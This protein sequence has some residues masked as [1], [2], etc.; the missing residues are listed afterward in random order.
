MA[1]ARPSIGT[2]RRTARQHLLSFANANRPA[3]KQQR[4]FVALII[5][6]S[7]P[8]L[9]QH[10]NIDVASRPC[11]KMRSSNWL[12][13]EI[14]QQRALPTMAIAADK[15]SPWSSFHAA[16][17]IRYRDDGSHRLPPP[18]KRAEYAPTSGNPLLY[19]GAA[20]EN[21]RLEPT[22]RLQ[23]LRSK[24]KYI[25][26]SSQWKTPAGWEAFPKDHIIS[27]A[28][29]GAAWCPGITPLR[30]APGQYSQATRS[31]G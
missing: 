23:P 1:P 6:P 4:S 15:L 22:L 12:R 2:A 30:T 31:M 8:A 20:P 17:L 29:S 24:E 25:Q 16:F 28:P 9:V 19:I 5:A 21:P 11:H 14:N 18:L 13:I 3:Q 10:S 26:D 7:T 27:R